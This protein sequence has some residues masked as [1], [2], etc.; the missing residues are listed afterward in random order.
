MLTKFTVRMIVAG[1]LAVGCDKYVL[2]VDHNATPL[3]PKPTEAPQGA[4]S[5]PAAQTAS[6]ADKSGIGPEHIGLKMYDRAN[7]IDAAAPVLFA[8]LSTDKPSRILIDFHQTHIVAISDDEKKMSIWKIE[9]IEKHDGKFLPEPKVVRTFR[10]PI[11][12]FCISK[13]ASMYALTTGNRLYVFGYADDAIA[14]DDDVPN[15]IDSLSFADNDTLVISAEGTTRL[16]GIK[17]D[18]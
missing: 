10:T 1:Q 5:V 3:P 2:V 4:P 6:K 9:D 8:S 11:D 16:L 18:K 12:A 15:K 14:S 13:G 7:G 17:K